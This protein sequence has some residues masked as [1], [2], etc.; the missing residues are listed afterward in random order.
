MRS[1]SISKLAI[2]AA[3]CL[4]PLAASADVLKIV[5]DDT[6]HPFVAEHIGRAIQEAQRLHADALLIELK[7]PGGLETSMEEIVNKILSSPVPVIVYVTP[8]GSAASSAGFYILE[9]ADIAAMTPGTSTGAAHPVREDGVTMD[10]VL[11][12]KWEN[13]AAALLRSYTGKR[14]RNVEV[15]ESAV[16][17]SKSFSADQALEQHLIE[18]IAKDEVDLM[19]QLEGKMITRF[20][21]SK[22]VLHV[23]GKRA[24]FYEMSLRERILSWL[25]DP[26]LALFL[27]TLGMMAL[28]AE[29]NHP[30]AVVPGVIGGIAVLVAIFA[31]QY[32]PVRYMALGL[33]LAAF[34]LFALEAKIHSHGALTIG[35]MVVL[36]LG[37]ML[38]VD[39]PIPEMRVDLLTAVSIAVPFGLITVF[40]MSVAMR[41][42]R[43]KVVTGIQGMIGAIGIARSPLVPAGK[44]FLQGEL[45]DAIAPGTVAAGQPVV[46]RSVENLTL[47]VEPAPEPASAASTAH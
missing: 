10:P 36:V 40:L 39:G 45:W 35:G 41:A 27:L 16:R 46:V 17:Q 8:Q 25:M 12:E 43:N 29:F 23:A 18:Y 9:S 2:I 38:L 15:A 32:L 37:S 30:G 28:Y 21:G 19:N 6:I 24:V 1:I 47:H 42:R 13:Y 4:I 44:V 14:G 5:V 26:K 22:S 11:K 33:I 7:T 34:V 31:L 20:D 3:V